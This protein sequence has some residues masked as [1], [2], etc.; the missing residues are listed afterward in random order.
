LPE[1]DGVS[2]K[3]LIEAPFSLTPNPPPQADHQV[4]GGEEDDGEE[5]RDQAERR[6]YL[7]A[8]AFEEL[9]YR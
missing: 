4:D 1:L 3:R 8:S 5:D 6:L 2:W 9:I 7:G